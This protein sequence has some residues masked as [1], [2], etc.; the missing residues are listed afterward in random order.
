MVLRS[1]PND[2]EERAMPTT[3]TS[4]IRKPAR[5]TDLLGHWQVEPLI[6]HARFGAPTLA[7]L[8]EASRR[9]RSIS[10]RLVPAEE[11]RR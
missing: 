6:S 11:F 4:E 7:G 1:D 8:V 5:D 9:F 2:D 10:G 3:A